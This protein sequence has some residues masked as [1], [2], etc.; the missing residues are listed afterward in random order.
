MWE[1]FYFLHQNG[2]PLTIFQFQAV[3]RRALCK[4]NL[5][6]AKLSSHSFRIGAAMEAARM[7][8]EANNIKK[9]GRWKSDAFKL[10]VRPNKLF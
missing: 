7:G 2:L 4:L 10:Y 3:L 1:N 8:L 5:G 9:L 6:G